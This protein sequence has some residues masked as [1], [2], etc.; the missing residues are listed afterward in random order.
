VLAQESMTIRETAFS[1]KTKLKPFFQK[2][3]TTVS[4]VHFMDIRPSMIKTPSPHRP[5]M[6][7]HGPLLFIWNWGNCIQNQIEEF[8]SDDFC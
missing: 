6:L 4:M 1:R 8:T 7:D 3:R 2:K 5:G